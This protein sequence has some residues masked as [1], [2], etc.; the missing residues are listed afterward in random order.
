[1]ELYAYGDGY[2]DGYFMLFLHFRRFVVKV[3][4]GSSRF[5]FWM[6]L[7]FLMKFHGY[8]RGINSN[9]LG[10]GPKQTRGCHVS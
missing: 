6:Q 4:C 3:I 7:G 9:E 8:K 2:G 10:D 5:Y 1:M